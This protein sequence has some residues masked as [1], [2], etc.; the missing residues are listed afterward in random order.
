MRTEDHN[1]NPIA[2]HCDAAFT[3][4]RRQM[5]HAEGTHEESSGT[6]VNT[7]NWGCGTEI[8][9]SLVFTHKGMR[10]AFADMSP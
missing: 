3:R 9:L 4:N 6:L 7:G 1:Q 5:V 8:T 2:D 10:M